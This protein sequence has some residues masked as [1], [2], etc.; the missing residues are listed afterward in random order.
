MGLLADW[1][2]NLTK[3]LAALTP[4]DALA[5]VTPQG[6]ARFNPRFQTENLS[7]LAGAQQESSAQRHVRLRIKKPD[8]L[9]ESKWDFR[10]LDDH[11]L[12]AKIT[13][14]P[15]LADFHGGH[16]T[17]RSGDLLEVDQRR[18]ARQRRG[19]HLFFIRPHFP[20]ASGRAA[21]W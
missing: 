21:V 15:W 8:F 10:R 9:G 12:A 4:Q 16:I 3:A 18:G 13:D 11:P 14:D 6:R 2:S 1:I 19:P 7:A 5:Y 20:A 17:I